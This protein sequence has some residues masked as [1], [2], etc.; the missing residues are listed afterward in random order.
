MMKK[1]SST[2]KGLYEIKEFENK[3]INNDFESAFDLQDQWETL[4]AR[5]VNNGL[6]WKLLELEDVYQSRLM[7]NLEDEGYDARKMLGP[8]SWDDFLR[9]EFYENCE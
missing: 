4:Y 5:C 6:L 3:L 9:Q 2:T 8:T 1:L 7:D